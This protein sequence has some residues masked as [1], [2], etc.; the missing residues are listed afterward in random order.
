[1]TK[2]EEID[3]LTDIYNDL[4]TTQDYCFILKPDCDILLKLVEREID[5]LS[6]A[7]NDA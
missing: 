4:N 6:G 5:E 2:E 1:M 7:N 3:M